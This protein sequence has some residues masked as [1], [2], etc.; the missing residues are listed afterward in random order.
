MYYVLSVYKHLS[1]ASDYIV[2]EKC[3]RA[4][5]DRKIFMRMSIHMSDS[6]GNAKE[7]A[8]EE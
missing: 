3:C 4:G 5:D 7:E 1:K 2:G 8:G 6:G